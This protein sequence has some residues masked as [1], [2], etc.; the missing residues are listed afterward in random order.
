MKQIIAII[1]FLLLSF[2]TTSH[3]EFKAGTYSF[4]PTLGLY[5]F[6]PHQ[7]LKS[8]ALAGL[9]ISRYL[10]PRWAMEAVALYVPTESKIK[11]GSDDEVSGIL[12]NIDGLYHFPIGAKWVPFL[13]A[14]VGAMT[15]G[16]NDTGA[17]TNLVLNYG[18]GIKYLYS[19]QMAIRADIRQVLVDD[20]S[21]EHNMVYTLGLE[22]FWGSKRPTKSL[23]K[24]DRPDSPN[25]IVQ[26]KTPDDTTEVPDKPTTEAKPEPKT[27]TALVSKTPTVSAGAAVKADADKD[28]VP[29]DRDF[30][31]N[32]PV[33]V[34]VDQDGCPVDSDG[35]G[36]PDYLDKCPGTAKGLITDKNGCVLDTDQDGVADSRDYCADTPLGLPVDDLGCPLDQD[37]DGVPDVKDLC[38]NTPV[39]SKVDPS[40]CVLSGDSDGDGVIDKLDRCPGTAI[41]TV[42]DGNGCAIPKDSDGDGVPDSKDFC[43]NTLANTPVDVSG[44]PIAKDSDGDGVIDKLDK[45]ANTPKGTQVNVN[46]CP[47]AIKQ[48]TTTESHIRFETGK[49]VIRSAFMVEVKR[50]ANYL[51]AFPEI[52]IEIEGHTDNTGPEKLNIRLS[53]ERA[54][55]LKNALVRHFGIDVSRVNTKGY[56][57]KRPIADN[58]TSEGREKNRRVVVTLYP[59]K[60]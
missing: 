19:E 37:G 35:D 21:T 32:T 54:E 1:F 60:K 50:I 56:S 44:C 14:G 10:N 47:I 45:C 27:E 43:A 55:S 57:F 4:T 39:G 8:S 3:A 58:N 22:F 9:R 16:G 48:K 11:P 51:K 24:L 18:G 34:V 41:G 49:S 26:Q 59:A 30:C 33:G 42:V 40:G 17:D 31:A 7:K 12:Y 46:G 53:D 2:T 25:T 20:N 36:T 29:D 52:T 15:L 38:P 6:D 23:A 13:A 28:G 5:S